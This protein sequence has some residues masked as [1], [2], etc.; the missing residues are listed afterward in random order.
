[1]VLRSVVLACNILH[2]KYQQLYMEAFVNCFILND[3]H[4]LYYFV[5]SS[6][7]TSSFGGVVATPTYILNTLLLPLT[8]SDA[9]EEGDPV[10]FMYLWMM[11]VQD[12]WVTNYICSI[13][14]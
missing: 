14:R 6:D 1:M 5:V 4:A 2:V 13:L 9:E 10:A 11:P 3:H 8:I 7:F 12:L